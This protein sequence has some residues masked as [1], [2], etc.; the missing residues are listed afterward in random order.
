[1]YPT[2]FRFQG[3]GFHMWGLMLMLGF[4]AAI[5][6][7][8]SRAKKVG[9]DP[10]L[11]VP[12]YQLIIISSLVGSRLLHF[13][14][15][16]SA[17]FFADPMIF[18]DPNQGGFAFYGGAIGGAIVGGWYLRWKKIHV[19]KLLDAAAPTMM[20]GLC[21][22][23][24][25][26]FFAGCCHGRLVEAAQTGT[27]FSLPGGSVVTLDA[28]PFF[29]FNFVDGVGVG[30]IHGAA[31]YPTQW[32]ESFGGLTIFL[33]LSWMWA[34]KRRFDGQIFATLLFI[35][36]LLRST[37]ETFRGDTVRGTDWM[38]LFS[39]S[40]LVS[41]PTLLL[42]AAIFAVQIRKGLAEESP[43]VDEE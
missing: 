4:T 41:I 15:A 13:V 10:D 1:M 3:Q 22:G 42:G 24:M 32:F 9:V 2:F 8:N 40:Q 23:R 14:F 18:F 33:F 6:T 12:F 19:W 38:G 21:L 7:L 26:C 27:L 31:I 16:E 17:A 43:Y 37:I 35:Y 34:N 11:L 36:P 25:G 20:L 30:S 5:L 39:T 28:A 29:A